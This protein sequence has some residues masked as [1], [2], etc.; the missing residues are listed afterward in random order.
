MASQVVSAAT[1]VDV[2]EFQSY[3]RGYH[4]YMET[5]TPVVGE[6]LLLRREPNNSKDRFAV[7][8]YKD[9]TVVGHVPYNIAPRLSQFLK[10]EVNKGFAEVTGEKLIRGTGYGLEIPCVY[11]LHGPKVYVDKMKELIGTLRETGRL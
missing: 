11:R 4:A 6:A 9:D 3:V 1:G 10:R 8:V 7:A 2:L 5:W